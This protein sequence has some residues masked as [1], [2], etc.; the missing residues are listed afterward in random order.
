MLMALVTVSAVGMGGYAQYRRLRRLSEVY[1]SRAAEHARQEARASFW[2]G[3]VE[4]GLPNV[5]HN[6]EILAHQRL[7]FSYYQAKV[8]HHAALMR[9]YTR[10]ASYPWLPVAPD[11]PE[12]PEPE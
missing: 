6:S 4:E 11:P 3:I 12:P 8:A 1:R 10:A 9:K 2:L 7:Q 5:T